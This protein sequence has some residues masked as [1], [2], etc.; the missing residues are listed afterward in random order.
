MIIVRDLTD[1]DTIKRY[2]K[3]GDVLEIFNMR[4][5]VAKFYFYYHGILSSAYG[6]GDYMDSCY[7]SEFFRDIR[8]A[9]YEPERYF[10]KLI[11]VDNVENV[12]LEESAVI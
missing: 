9:L 2:M 10:V 12:R 3:L 11:E 1:I 7:D 5:G 4:Y 8:M 6:S